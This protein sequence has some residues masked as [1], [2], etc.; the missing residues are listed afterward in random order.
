MKQIPSGEANIHSA[1]QVIL[2][3]LYD[4]NAYYLLTKEAIFSSENS[5][6]FHRYL[7][8]STGVRASNPM[9][10]T[11]NHAVYFLISLTFCPRGVVLLMSYF[12]NISL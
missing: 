3:A 2:S 5:V 9:T 1:G 11:K 6:D 4:K 7:P 8:Q 12:D 10:A